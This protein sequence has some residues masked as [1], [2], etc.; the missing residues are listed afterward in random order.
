MQQHSLRRQKRPDKENNLMYT[1]IEETIQKD[2]LVFEKLNVNREGAVL[3]AAINAPP[4]NLEGPELV[5]DLVSLIQKAEAD[6]TVRVLVFKSADPDYFISH[7]DVTRIK[8]NREAATKLSGDPSIGQ[9]LRHL[10]A[11]RIVSI[12]QIEGRVRGV[13]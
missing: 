3:F 4:M 1:P 5:R 2:S 13:G 6:D 8:E 11:S 9:M 7:V 12:A 10:S